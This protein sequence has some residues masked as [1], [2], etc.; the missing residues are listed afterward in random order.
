MPTVFA[1]ES[2]ETLVFQSLMK[3]G[4]QKSSAT[5]IGIERHQIKLCDEKILAPALL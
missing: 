3:Q 4:R 2:F 1:Q 5:N